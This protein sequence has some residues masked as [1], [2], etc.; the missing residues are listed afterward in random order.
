MTSKNPLAFLICIL[1][2]AAIALPVFSDTGGNVSITAVVFKRNS[3]PYHTIITISNRFIVLGS[4]SRAE[5]IVEAYGGRIL[6]VF[7]ASEGFVI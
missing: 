2:L 4:T 5:S 3:S 7:R 1:V 6:D